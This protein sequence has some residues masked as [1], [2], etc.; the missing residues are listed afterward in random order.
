MKLIRF[1][2]LAFVGLRQHVSSLVPVREE[3]WSPD[4]NVHI[5]VEY[6]KSPEII[7]GIEGKIG[8]SGTTDAAT[9]FSNFTSPLDPRTEPT[10]V[11]FPTKS[12]T[13]TTKDQEEYWSPDGQWHITVSREDPDEIEPVPTSKEPEVQTSGAV[14]A[15]T[16]N[17]E[18]SSH[19]PRPA[20]KEETSETV[21]TPS[22]PPAGVSEI[23]TTQHDGTVPPSVTTTPRVT[24]IVPENAE[25]SKNCK[26]PNCTCSSQSPPA[27]LGLDDMP[28]FVMLTFDGAV[29]ASNMPFYRELLGDLERR[30]KASDCAIAATFFVSADRLEFA[31]LNELYAG[32]NEIALHSISHHA[33]QA[34]WNDLDTSGWELEVADEKKMVEAFANIPPSAIKG[35][36]GPNLMTGG[37]QG[38]KMIHSNLEYD[39]SLVHPRTRPDTRPTFP[40]T[41]DFGFKE[42]CVVERCPQEAY[43]GLWVMPLNVLFKKSD[44]DGGSQELPCSM[45]DGCETQPSSADETFEYLRSNFEDFYKSN[46]AP[47][48]VSVHEA[49]LHDPQR[50][51]GYLRF[52]SWL[53]EK[54]DVHL[55][56]VSEVLSF[57][58][59]PTPENK[60]A[61]SHCLK[62]KPESTCPSPKSCEYP[63]TPAGGPRTTTVC[64][65]DCPP[66]YPWLFSPLG[67][68]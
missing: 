66:K 12:A 50:K 4:K 14:T 55:V 17:F 23:A 3:Y 31:L 40:Y 10:I 38:F 65:A 61:Q 13:P 63:S 59:N 67:K 43:P 41:L 28:Q 45:A 64:T 54:D 18:T 26:P 49:W 30:N 2:V 20:Q 25:C 39:S 62:S 11:T 46:R 19:V 36:R 42:K 29:N 7:P 16:T 34:Y 68:E 6:E 53:L 52:V 24:K 37:D 48:P 35:F 51:E 8:Q 21:T 57:M 27:G 32:G 5:I 33:D 58:R 47:F 1:I 15:T 22:D 56:T 9:P 44:V 60:Y